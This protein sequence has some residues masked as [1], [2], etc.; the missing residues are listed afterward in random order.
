MQSLRPSPRKNGGITSAGHNEPG[1]HSLSPAPRPRS[2]G[3][4]AR[5]IFGRG[6]MSALGTGGNPIAVGLT[7]QEG[8]DRVSAGA[9]VDVHDRPAAGEVMQKHLGRALLG[10]EAVLEVR[11]EAGNIALDIK[12]E[13]QCLAVRGN[14]PEHRDFID[15]HGKLPG[16]C[17]G[18]GAERFLEGLR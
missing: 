8:V 12:V 17:F 11:S 2:G 1:L 13:L 15:P 6:G 9:G 4:G 18:L 7:D 3:S 16:A 14:F 10:R 5:H